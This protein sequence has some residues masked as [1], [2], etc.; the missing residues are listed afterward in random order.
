MLYHTNRGFNDNSKMVA[1]FF[2]Q[3]IFFHIFLIFQI[4]AF[5]RF[6]SSMVLETSQMLA[7]KDKRPLNSMFL[8]TKL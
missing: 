7:H 6:L 1:M 5:Y 4:D 8:E 3:R 2:F